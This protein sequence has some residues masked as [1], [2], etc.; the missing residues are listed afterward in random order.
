MAEQAWALVGVVVGAILGGGAQVLAVRLQ[1]RE[2]HRQ[3]VRERRVEVYQRYLAEWEARYDVLS[4][5][6]V[7]G[8]YSD[9]PDDYLAP[10]WERT[11]EVAVF[12]SSAATKIAEEGRAALMNLA[13]RTTRSSPE[14]AKHPRD[15]VDAFRVQIRR[16]LRVD[17]A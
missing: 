9:P 15:V 2:R 16:D 7:S 5:V 3:W 17:D 1:D 12:G 4:S 10:L 13:F 14:P 6:H 11:Q 8:D